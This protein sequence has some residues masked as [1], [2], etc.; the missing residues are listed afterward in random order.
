VQKGEDFPEHYYPAHPSRTATEINFQAIKDWCD[1]LALALTD[2]NWLEIDE[3]RQ[4]TLPI[5]LSC[6]GDED[7]ALKDFCAERDAS[8]EDIRRYFLPFIMPAV[9]QL[10][11]YLA[12]IKHHADISMLDDDQGPE[13][14]CHEGCGTV[15]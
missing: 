12:E 2:D 11:A 13:H 1:G 5:M 8:A 6:A 14:Q 3:Y 10:Y 7:T 4:L 9:H 15:H